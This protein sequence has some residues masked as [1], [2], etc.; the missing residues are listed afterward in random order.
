MELNPWFSEFMWMRLSIRVRQR[1]EDL[2]FKSRVRGFSALNI[3]Y[4]AV[5]IQQSSCII[6]AF[7]NFCLLLNRCPWN[8]FVLFAW[9][10]IFDNV[11]ITKQYNLIIFKEANMFVKTI[12]LWIINII[13]RFIKLFIQPLNILRLLKVKNLWTPWEGNLTD[14]G[15]KVIFSVL[16]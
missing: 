8:V 10:Q 5:I 1:A 6:T 13:H 14:N 12:V 9:L 3:N 16:K 2:G 15:I 7:R 4:I 11:L